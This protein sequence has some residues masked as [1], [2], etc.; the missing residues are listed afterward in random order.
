MKQTHTQHLMDEMKLLRLWTWETQREKEAADH[1]CA[2]KPKITSEWVSWRSAVHSNNILQFIKN[3]RMS[4][5]IR[6]DQTNL[7]TKLHDSD[8]TAVFCDFWWCQSHMI[9]EYLY[10]ISWS[11][12]LL[13]RSV[14][15]H[16]VLYMLLILDTLFLF[17]TVTSLD[18]DADMFPWR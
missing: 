15:R 11:H 17:L 18:L 14:E 5:K 8:Y 1:Q 13:C 12:W 4:L 10:L 6:F 3:K 9:S 2:E 7:Q 16:A